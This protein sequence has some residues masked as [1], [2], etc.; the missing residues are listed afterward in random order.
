MKKPKFICAPTN[1]NGE[2]P[3]A[4]S[5]PDHLEDYSIRPATKLTQVV[6][7]RIVNQFGE[8]RVDLKKPVALQV[9]TAKDPDG[10]PPAE[11]S[12]PA[13]DHFTCYKVKVTSGTPKFVRQ[14]G[15][16]LQ[17]Q[18]GSMTVDVI[19][20]RR[21]CLPTNKNAEEPGAENH[22]DHLM[23]Y[24]IRQTSL[25][26]F[27][28]V[29]GIFTNNQFSPGRL[30]ARKPAEVCVPS[31]RNPPTGPTVTPTP[32]PT[33]TP[34][35]PTATL[36]PT[37]TPTPPPGCGNG[38][39]DGSEECDPPDEAACPGQCSAFCQC[40]DCVLPN[41]MPEVLSFAAKP[42]IDLDT[43]WTGHSHDLP[44]VD[45]GSLTAVRLQN[46]DTDTDRRR[47]GSATSMDRSSSRARRRTARAST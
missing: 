26:K 25:P 13:V 35:G 21:L 33:P 17:D 11:P 38:M 41:P 3:T 45:D 39:I 42:G 2:D 12:S 37:A 18:F 9:P 28:K 14:S 40:I 5:H 31:L 29:P 43:G 44:G 47:A 30:D 23:C 24:R 1:K 7:Q 6:N 22:P 16:T 4:P 15:V 36:T 10:P 46:C 20:P 19:K 27:V 34:T 8:I 32:T